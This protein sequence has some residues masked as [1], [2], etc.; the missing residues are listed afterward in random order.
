M[1]QG[2]GG[3]FSPPPANLSD[4]A[5][6]VAGWGGGPAS[7]R[8]TSH[9]LRSQFQVLRSANVRAGVHF[10][11]GTAF[12]REVSAEILL[13]RSS[14]R[15]IRRK[16]P[17]FETTIYFFRDR[18]RSMAGLGRGH[19]FQLSVLSSIRCGTLQSAKT[20]IFLAACES[21]ESSGD[22]CGISGFLK[23]TAIPGAS[24]R[25]VNHAELFAVAARF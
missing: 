13:K 1:E 20:G 4:T 21:R 11:T 17:A 12:F 16:T 14:P 8:L 18:G 6:L 25:L 5:F 9:L 19:V 3:E 7:M 23:I 15:P 10:L 2:I 22:F 24:S